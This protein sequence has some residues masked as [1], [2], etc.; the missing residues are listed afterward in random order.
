M[1]SPAILAPPGAAPASD[2]DGTSRKAGPAGLRRSDFEFEL[3][4]ELIAQ[5]PAARRED[6]RL[7]HVCGD[8][9]LDEGIPDLP[10][11]FQDG[12]V[13]VLN[14]TKVI[15]A[16][17]QGAKASGGRVEALL[18]RVLSA[19]RALVLLR[20]SHSPRPGL[21]MRFFRAG[22]GLPPPGGA[23]LAAGFDA[24]LV[25]RQDDLFELE[26]D[27]PLEDVLAAAGE[28]PLPPYIQHAPAAD[29]AARYQTVYARAPGA[30]AAPTAGLHLSEALLQRL[31]KRGVQ[32]AYVTLH[33]G[34]GTFQPVRSENLREHRMHAERYEVPERTAELIGTAKARG[35][36]VVAAGTT[37]VRALESSVRNGRVRAGAGETTLFIV[38]G[39]EF[40]CVD[41][42]ITNFHLPGS[43]LLVLV[44]AF[45]GMPRV[46]RAYAHAIAR[47]YRFFSYGDAM[48]LEREGIRR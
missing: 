39:Y 29:D 24:T 37:S 38:P 46:R 12:D 27:D 13:L 3:P 28:V 16:R 1:A 42:L 34:A 31:Q 7:L 26:F 47:R 30:V 23:G 20:T 19:R 36:C 21:R 41:R 10:S 25:G 35:R 32:L 33:V 40:A 17:L 11:K 15:P 44:S 18:E 2:G 22:K 4:P 5:H 48:L 6:A 9:L 14:D 8:D 43:T 45:A